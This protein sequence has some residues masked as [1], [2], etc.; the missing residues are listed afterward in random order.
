MRQVKE[1]LSKLPA[2]HLG[3]ALMKSR[4]S[5]KQW[6]NVL[7]MNEAMAAEYRTRREMLLKRLD[8]TIQSFQWSDRAKVSFSHEV[9]SRM[10]C[11]HL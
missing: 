4:L 10:G 5:D 1:V 9:N 6:T 2:D 7:A 8:V 11:V 3:K